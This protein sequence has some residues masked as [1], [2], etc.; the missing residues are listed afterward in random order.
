MKSNDHSSSL[1]EA[2]MLGGVLALAALPLGFTLQLLFSGTVAL[3]LLWAIISLSYLLL[4]PKTTR[5][6]PAGI[7]ILALILFGSA[8][9]ASTAAQALL[10]VGTIWL[11]R[12]LK[13]YRSVFPA[14]LDL[15]LTATSAMFALWTFSRT[16]SIAASLWSFFLLQALTP[17]LPVFFPKG[18]HLPSNSKPPTDRFEHAY[19]TAERALRQIIITGEL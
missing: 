10:C 13:T 6:R 14:F 11:F 12:S 9:L 18:R 16:G 2:V 1:A 7:L 15:L 17:T 4:A 5:R 8:F 19:S 3:R